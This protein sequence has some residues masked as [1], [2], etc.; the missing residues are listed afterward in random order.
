MSKVKVVVAIAVP[1]SKPDA[2][3]VR[4]SLHQGTRRIPDCEFR[5]CINCL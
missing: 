2:S 4:M 3:C 5:V 1:A